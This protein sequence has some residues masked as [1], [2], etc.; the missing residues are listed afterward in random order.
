MCIMITFQ[1]P[2]QNGRNKKEKKWV[3]ENQ[4]LAVRRRPGSHR[5]AHHSSIRYKPSQR[6]PVS[7]KA[8]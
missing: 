8:L 1:W 3:R 6:I 2:D 5:E 7:G 4:P